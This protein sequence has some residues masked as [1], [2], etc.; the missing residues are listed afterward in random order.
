MKIGLAR[1]ITAACTPAPLVLIPC[2]MPF[3]SISNLIMI[4]CAVGIARR[5][6]RRLHTSCLPQILQGYKTCKCHASALS[7][8]RAFC[9]ESDIFGLAKAMQSARSRF[10][11][12]A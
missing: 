12:Q 11:S 6:H 9:R 1:L 7:G 4:L 5:F 3:S 2:H 8:A 10:C